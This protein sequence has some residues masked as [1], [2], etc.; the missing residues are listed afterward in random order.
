ME[1]SGE[2]AA[3][4]LVVL[5]GLPGAGKSTF[6]RSLQSEVTLKHP[7]ILVLI[8]EYDE[9]IKEITPA[10]W[11]SQ[12][13]D[14][15]DAVSHLVLGMQCGSMAQ[16]LSDL[17]THDLVRKILRR[18][19]LTFSLILQS[20]NIVVILD[21]NMYYRSM[22]YQIYQLALQL[23]AGFCQIYISVPLDIVC[24]QN[25]LRTCPVS[26]EVITRMA[27]V[28]EPPNPS[29]FKFE[30][31]TIV[32]NLFS[33][34]IQDSLKKAINLIFESANNPPSTVDSEEMRIIS[35]ERK[36]CQEI[37][38]TS[39]LHHADGILRALVQNKCATAK[40]QNLNLQTV[41]LRAVDSR[42]KVLRKFRDTIPLDFDLKS[43]F[44][45]QAILSREFNAYFDE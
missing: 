21:D 4:V 32:L 33:A 24:R 2:T 20:K 44:D 38:R 9:L 10:Y 39:L 14:V 43:S 15:F 23:R 26:E 45:M 36:R 18:N 8:V 16:Q 22:R 7:D 11:K 30:H 5:S 29:R 40:F 3:T 31:F 42:K 19:G 17:G 12:R 6:S 27:A 13:Q 37:N 25:L 1:S 41:S 28:F 34:T 35:E